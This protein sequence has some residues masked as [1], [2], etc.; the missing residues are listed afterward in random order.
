MRKTIEVTAAQGLASIIQAWNNRPHGDYAG[1]FDEWFSA[2]IED[3][4]YLATG[5]NLIYRLEVKGEHANKRQ[6]KP[7]AQEREEVRGDQDQ[8]GT[9]EEGQGQESRNNEGFLDQEG[10]E[11]ERETRQGGRVAQRTLG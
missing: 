9:Q 7:A 8:G 2:N 3:Y 6:G 4:E 10:Q 11:E 1:S 5:L